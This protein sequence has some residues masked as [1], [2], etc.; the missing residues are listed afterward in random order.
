MKLKLTA[1]LAAISMLV[2]VAGAGAQDS[3]YISK[4]KPKLTIKVKPKR[5]KTKPFKFKVSGKLKRNGVA[6]KKACKGTVTVR[7]NG[8]SANTPVKK[9]CSYSKRFKV[10]KE[11]KYRVSAKF[12][13]NARLRK[14]RSKTVTVKAG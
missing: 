12:N 11:G 7:V 6:K 1:L 9:N 5:D 13:G 2:L 4:V 8:A 14:A 3:Y 10:S